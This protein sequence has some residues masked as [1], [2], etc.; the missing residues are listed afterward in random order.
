[1]LECE[2]QT[3]VD[4]MAFDDVLTKL[5]PE[6]NAVRFSTLD[7]IGKFYYDSHPPITDVKQSF[8]IRPY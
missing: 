5:I 4:E 7:E 6:V 3:A 8:T 2:I 1:M